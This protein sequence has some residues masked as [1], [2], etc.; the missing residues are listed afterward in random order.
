M[1]FVYNIGGVFLQVFFIIVYKVFILKILY[2]LIVSFIREEE[3]LVH[4]CLFLFR[5]GG[6]LAR[7]GICDFSFFFSLFFLYI[8]S[9]MEGLY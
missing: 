2:L 8:Y 3:A 9:N 5:G 7:P 1:S 6:C 4:F